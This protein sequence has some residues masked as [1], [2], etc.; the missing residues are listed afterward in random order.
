[1]TVWT[2]DTGVCFELYY[3]DMSTQKSSTPVAE[4]IAPT[5]VGLLLGM[6]R[7][8]DIVTAELSQGLQERSNGSLDALERLLLSEGYVTDHQLAQMKAQ[9][10]GWHYVD[11]GA[12]ALDTD[13]LQRIP[14]AF[15][16]TQQAVPYR[17]Q[18]HA[19]VAMTH[20]ENTRIVRVLQKKMG[21][22]IRCSLASA[23][24]VVAA[25]SRH[26]THYASKAEACVT[27]FKDAKRLHRT[28]DPSAIT[29]IDSILEHAV[30]SRA[31]DIHIE[32]RKEQTS[33]R[34][35]TDGV[36]Q[37]WLKLP[38]AMHELVLSRIKV[39]SNIATDEHAKPQDGKM[40]YQTPEGKR[41]DIRVSVS[42]T[43]DGEKIVLRLLAAQDRS[44]SL[45]YL[46][47][48]TE[49]LQRLST[50][51]ERPWGMILVTGPTGSGKTTTLYAG[52]RKLHRDDVNIETIEDPVEYDVPGV[53]QMQ[54]NE[55]AGVNFATGLRAIVRQDPDIILVGEIRDRETAGIA[56][57]AAMTGHLVLSTLH[58]NDAATTIPRL[59]D[60]GIEPFLIAS[61]INV[62]VAQRLVR[63]LCVRCRESVDMDAATLKETL[64]PDMLRKMMGA[65]KTV[66]LYKGK[67]CDACNQTGFHGRSGIFEI[68]PITQNIRDLIMQRATAEAIES[69]AAA[70]GMKTMFEDG[71]EK[72]LQGMTTIEEV[73]RVT[74]V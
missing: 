60:M 56:V 19:G 14:A 59:M 44:V 65:G 20:P 36:L 33:I 24:E 53:N 10:F 37:T 73:M 5:Q 69:A 70:D 26:D 50:Q 68:L 1:M 57:N 62:I 18:G 55:K 67:G 21:P 13:M 64:K 32:P 15:L 40:D 46:G 6:L 49:D 34:E 51:M 61:T 58:T 3:T 47:L 63:T 48:S 42:P 74:R 54:V 31:S 11:L 7:K 27:S 39:L 30:H 45:E 23:S 28:D 29:L 25:L 2:L 66:R 8:S 35:R 71:M 52:I 4:N 41:V 16:R 22:D 43:I 17:L 9:V 38:K 72:V 12:S